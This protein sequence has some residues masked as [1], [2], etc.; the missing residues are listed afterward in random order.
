[1]PTSYQLHNIYY[2]SP[3]TP[4]PLYT[5]LSPYS[6]QNRHRQLNIR[7]IVKWIIHFFTTFGAPFTLAFT[8]PFTDFYY[9]CCEFFVRV[10]SYG[11]TL[12]FTIDSGVFQKKIAPSLPTEI[13]VLW[14]GEILTLLIEP[15]CPSP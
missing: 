3:P 7:R 9:T 11:Y 8:L 4:Q 10:G 5:T 12:S 2:N 1:M 6:D 13:M 14:S 15:E